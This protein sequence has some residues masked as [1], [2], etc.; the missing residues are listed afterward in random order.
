MLAGPVYRQPL[1]VPHVVQGWPAESGSWHARFQL[2]YLP[3]EVRTWPSGFDTGCRCRAAAPVGAQTLGRLAERLPSEPHG[4][5][6]SQSH[7]RNLPHSPPETSTVPAV[8]SLPVRHASFPPNPLTSTQK[9]AD[10]G[11]PLGGFL[12]SL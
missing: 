9:S 8:N 12:G 1:P 11:L 3:A 7:T 6:D 10:S 5:L 2:L 4:R